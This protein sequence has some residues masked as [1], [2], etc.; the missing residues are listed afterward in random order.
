MQLLCQAAKFCQDYSKY[1][2][3]FHKYTKKAVFG[4]A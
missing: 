2:D 1:M 4:P 3:M